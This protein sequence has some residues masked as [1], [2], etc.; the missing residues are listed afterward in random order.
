MVPVT[1][2]RSP[3]RSTRSTSIMVVFMSDSILMV[4]L[5]D[6]SDP[7]RTAR[8]GFPPRWPARQRGRRLT[9]GSPFPPL[10][11]LQVVQD[12]AGGLSSCSPCHPDPVAGQ[13]QLLDRAASGR[14]LMEGPI[15]PDL[16]RLR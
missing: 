5:T 15:V 14:I 2:S 6:S 16:V 8:P 9:Q 7:S 10:L 1:M 4:R 13:V 12:Q 3:T 11:Q